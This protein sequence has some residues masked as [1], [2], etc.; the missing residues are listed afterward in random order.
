[1]HLKQAFYS[2]II[3]SVLG[4]FIVLMTMTPIGRIMD[5]KLFSYA[6]GAAGIF[7]S[8]LALIGCYLMR[9]GKEITAGF[10]ILVSAVGGIISMSLYYVIPGFLLIFAGF[11]AIVKKKEPSADAE[12]K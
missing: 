11:T 4:L 3:G 7:F 1:M 5:L 8:V 10:L 9:R 2:G 12:I 6:M